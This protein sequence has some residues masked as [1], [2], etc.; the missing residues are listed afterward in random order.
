[1]WRLTDHSATFE[2]PELAGRINTLEPWQGW[3]G[4]AV[5]GNLLP[6]SVLQ[7]DLRELVA[8]NRLP[9]DLYTR[10]CD[11][12]ATYAA[13]ESR[14]VQTQLYW[15]GVDFA[16]ARGLEVILSAQ[17]HLLDSRPALATLSHLPEGDVLAAVDG[18]EPTPVEVPESGRIEFPP[19]D[20]RTL[21]LIRP[22]GADYSYA[23]MVYPADFAGAAL[24]RRGESLRISQ[25]LFPDRLEK[26]VIRR[27]RLCGLFLPRADDVSTA[28]SAW[29]AF[30]AEPLP[31]TA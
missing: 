3:H 22:H 20:P 18:D 23:E 10:G 15:R 7:I 26:G 29:Q 4:I 5:R 31:L 1:M 17:T 8:P 12:V 9:L 6:C 28:R 27:G 14:N 24:Q 19:S 11:L 25:Q 13:S 16:G 30:L 2:S 21:L